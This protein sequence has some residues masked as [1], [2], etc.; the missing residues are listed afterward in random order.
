M[1]RRAVTWMMALAAILAMAA[2]GAPGL[3]QGDPRPEI[4]V[5]LQFARPGGIYDPAQWRYTSDWFVYPSLFNWLVRW[6]PGTFGAQLEPDLAERYTVSADGLV[7]TFYLRRGVQFHKGFGELTA[8]DVVFSFTRQMADEKMSFYDDL[9][10]VAGVEAVDRYTVRIRLKEPNAAFLPTVIA[11]RPGLIVSKRAVQQLGG[12]EFAKAPVG[13]GPYVFER[14]VGG[15]E[16]VVVAHDRYFKGR[17]PVR[18]IT[19]VHIPDEVVAATALIRGEFHVIWTRGNPEAVRLL[20]EARGQGIQLQRNVVYDSVRHIS[21]SPA[22]RPT[23]DVRVR[24]AL[25]HAINR[26]QIAAALPGLELPTDVIRSPRLF[27][28]TANVPRYPYNPERARQ[29][30]TEAGYPN[31]FRV[32]IMYQTRSPEDILASI[33]QAAWRAVGIEATLDP[34][35]PTAAFDRRNRGDFEVT[36]NSVGRPADPDLFYSDLFLSTAKPPGGS[37]FGGYTGVDELIYAARREQNRAR[38]QRLYDQLN[39]KLMTDLPI[40]PLSYQVFV[41]AWR[42]PIVT[43]V[44]GTNNDFLS[45]TIRV[46]P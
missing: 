16:V 19:F 6:K 5:R 10:Q 36:V 29:L 31:G 44:N 42:D 9:R 8:E 23:Q 28:G 27:G 34:A 43:M 17:P 7:Y 40:I 35:E 3:A 32:R 24:R 1:R 4:R 45:E 46:R 38:R 14:L 11:Y 39:R 21:M 18:R 12:A 26:Q 25:S 20:Q 30:L 13:T 41:A 2:T 33:V 22:F 37:N 15:R